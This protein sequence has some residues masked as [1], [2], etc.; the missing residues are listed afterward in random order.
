MKNFTLF[1][2]L[3]VF[4]L[5]LAGCSKDAE[6]E[7]FIT[8]NDAVMKDITSKI[9]QNPTSAGVDDAQKSFDAKKASL[10]QKWDAIKDARGAQV[11]SETQKK[12]NDSM[13][14][15]MKQLTDV[16]MKNAMKLAQDRDAAVK[17]Q[18]LM[19]DYGSTF[20]QP[21]GA[22]GGQPTGGSTK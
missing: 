11:S 4:C 9:D 5:G 22:T 3:A 15:N 14:N 6:V 17:F 7:A 16:S 12:L 8:E 2:L 21:G 20:G 19:Q 18:K 1:L 10:K 13:S